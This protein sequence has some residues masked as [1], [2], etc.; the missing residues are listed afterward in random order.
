MA[1]SWRSHRASASDA[2]YLRVPE[3]DGCEI[4]EVTD[5]VPSDFA[6]SPYTGW[7]RDHYEAVA[8]KLCR[9]FLK[10]R[11]VGHSGA[12]YAGRPS[13]HGCDSMEA[14]SRLLPILGSWLADPS[15]PRV[16]S[17]EGT[18]MDLE[19]LAV[20]GLVNG[21]CP[22][23]AGYWG[24]IG[25]YDQ[26][27]V[28][29]TEVALFLWQTRD[30][31]WRRLSRMHQAQIM[32]WLSQVDNVRVWD[33]NWHLFV[34]LNQA[35]RGQLGAR[36]DRQSLRHHLDRVERLYLGDGWYGDGDYAYVDWYNAWEIHLHLMLWAMI[37]GEADPARRERIIRR[38][39]TFLASL[40][41]FFGADGMHVAFGR[42]L[43]Y[44]FA[45]VAAI[46]V[47]ARMGISPLS[48]GLARRIVSGSIRYFVENGA[49][50]DEIL[51]QGVVGPN[52][53]ALERYSG[54]ASPYWATRAL[55]C[56]WLP[57][58]D[59]F[60]VAREE[61]LPVEESDFE[62]ALPGPRFALFGS[63]RSGHVQLMRGSSCGDGDTDRAAKYG[64]LQ[65]SSS[66]PFNVVPVDGSFPFD[67]MI[68]LTANGG[69]FTHRTTTESGVVAPGFCFVDFTVSAGGGNHKVRTAGIAV[70]D[71][72]FRLT[73]VEPDTAVPVKAYEA[74]YP[75]SL[76][77]F[78]A[79][80]SV[81]HGRRWGVVRNAGGEATFIKGFLAYDLV[82]PDSDFKGRT[83][84]NAV[85]AD[86]V[87]PVVATRAR[88]STRFWTASFSVASRRGLDPEECAQ[89]VV[90]LNPGDGPGEFTVE[91]TDGDHLWISVARAMPKRSLRLGPVSLS[92]SLRF[93]R[94]SR[95][96]RRIVAVGAEE[97][98][99]TDAATL[100]YRCGHEG[101]ILEWIRENETLTCRLSHPAWI[102][103]GG[104]PFV[105]RSRAR[106][107]ARRPKGWVAVP[108][109][110]MAGYGEPIALSEALVGAELEATECEL[111]T[112]E[113]RFE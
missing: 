96:G 11:T 76:D 113:C 50:Q 30:R 52:P 33:N 3:R 83:D 70:R 55:Y 97:I 22:G 67:S 4:C 45:V 34:A 26:R 107:Y 95:D 79:E 39:R 105:P 40:P 109:G 91:L 36:M 71:G 56:L 28:E 89:S 18:L 81:D 15:G 102:G 35:A 13:N 110:A 90:S 20:E 53:R 100:L 112:F 59:P 61:P 104:S 1:R 93:A 72:I 43:L 46:P 103:P 98:R 57:A 21:T 75:I 74:G 106:L 12:A 38:A 42:S 37:D 2:R 24:N 101:S 66:F 14:F 99:E 44:R 8:A 85:H 108:G 94:V 92:G 77:A 58:D 82:V 41:Y 29:A 54:P 62:I 86:A 16:I 9:G 111:A 88:H 65:Y 68:S 60:W 32:A 25:D 64:K 31:V 51:T 5:A 63:K 84:L 69:D 78:P 47:A 23:R 27:T 49:L 6:C 10:H 48:P 7:V 73:E 17:Y 80:T 87:Q 19:E